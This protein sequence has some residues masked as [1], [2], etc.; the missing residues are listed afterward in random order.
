MRAFIINLDRAPDRWAFVE[1]SFA[2]TGIEVC[3]VPGIDGKLL[4]QPCD[5]YPDALYHRYHGRPNTPGTTGCFLS[6]VKALKFFLETGDAH[7]IIVEDDAQLGPKFEKVMAEAMR[8]SGEWDILRLTGL[9]DGMPMR[10]ADLGDGYSL[11]VSLGRLKGL[12][13]YAVNRKAAERWVETLL[14]MRV[15]VDHAMD[16]EWFCGLRAM[17]VQPFPAS[18]T[19]HDFKSS[20]QIGKSLKLP[21]WRRWLTTYPYQVFNEVTRW[22][23]RIASYLRMKLLV[24]R[25]EGL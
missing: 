5:D 1:R 14:P 20:I 4:P 11:N 24:R 25:P 13:V 3:R 12:G 18:Q 17:T 7:G 19:D 9:S 15:P 22:V 21:A 23:F 10:V 8:Y 16:R 2:G 6:H